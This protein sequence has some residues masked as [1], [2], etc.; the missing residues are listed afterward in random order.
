[1]LHDYPDERIATTAL[2]KFSSC[3]FVSLSK[4]EDEEPS[5][6]SQRDSCKYKCLADFVTINTKQFF[7]KLK[8]DQKFLEDDPNSWKDHLGFQL[9]LLFVQII[10]IINESAERGLT[11][12]VSM[13][14]VLCCY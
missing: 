2:N 10:E 1:M 7:Q 14:F 13:L 11:C 3:M 9:A 12:S 5:K 4:V 8:L 6:C